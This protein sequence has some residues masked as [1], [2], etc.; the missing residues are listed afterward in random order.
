MSA[1]RV[2]AGTADFSGQ[3]VNRLRIGAM[4]ARRPEPRYEAV[5]EIC[6][7]KTTETQSRIRSG[8]AR[9]LSANCGKPARARR[10][11]GAVE[12]H[13]PLNRSSVSD[14][15][16]QFHAEEAEHE[17]EQLR[18][19]N[20]REAAENAVQAEKRTQAVREN[21][22]A[23]LREQILTGPDP[24]FYFEPELAR[25][26]MRTE[27]AQ[28]YNGEQ[29]HKFLREVPEYRQFK[30]DDSFEKISAY[31][32]INNCRIFSSEM[33]R[34]A[35]FRLRDL[36]V[37]QPNPLPKVEPEPATKPAPVTVNLNVDGPLTEQGWDDSGRPLTLTKRQIDRLGSTEY[38]RFKRLDR[39]ALDDSLPRIGPG[40]R[41]RR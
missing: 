20:E 6:G 21:A 25:A 16:R 38:R 2:M 34:A 9:C 35:F 10:S 15:V 26:S 14:E 8:V 18:L 1:T 22:K 23:Y 27:D 33:I 13:V 31:F 28:K 41:G 5:C 29:A 17:A 19:K 24:L 30:S 39:A 7:T 37:I 32:E 40:P 36:G 11:I 3:T 12:Q 4:V